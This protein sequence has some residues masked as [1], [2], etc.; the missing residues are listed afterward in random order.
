MRILTVFIG[1]LL[2]IL[3]TAQVSALERTPSANSFTCRIVTGYGTAIGQG[4]TKLEAESNARLLCGTKLIDDY[5]A[6][7]ATIDPDADL[8]L[9]CINLPCQ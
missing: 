7:R 6:R 2:V 4:H 5:F 1:A 8:E 3:M 9:A